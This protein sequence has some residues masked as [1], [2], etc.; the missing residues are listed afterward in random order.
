MP[1]WILSYPE[2][3]SPADIERELDI[4]QHDDTFIRMNMVPE[5]E[6]ESIEIELSSTGSV[7]P[8]TIDILR[9]RGAQAVPMVP[10]IPLS[11]GNEFEVLMELGED[12]ESGTLQVGLPVCIDGQGRVGLQGAPIGILTHV[13]RVNN[14]ARVRIQPG[15]PVDDL[16]PP[17]FRLNQ[18]PPL[19]RE[20]LEQAR[21]AV[22]RRVLLLPDDPRIQQAHQQILADED[23]RVFAVLDSIALGSTRIDQEPLRPPSSKSHTPEPRPTFKTRYQRI[24][25]ALKGG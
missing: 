25:D 23:A 22:E 9:L 18:P 1:T 16:P 19:T 12:Q 3:S 11:R 10:S 24:M 14:Q 4:I 7:D 13:D 2:E 15:R 8:R 21:L 6:S 20:G 5:D 17:P